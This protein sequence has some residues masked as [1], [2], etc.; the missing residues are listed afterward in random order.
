MRRLGTLI[1]GIVLGCVLGA[2]SGARTGCRVP[3]TSRIA[4]EAAEGDSRVRAFVEK[5]FRD[6]DLMQARAYLAEEGPNQ[7]RWQVEIS[8]RVCGCEGVAYMNVVRA[9]VDPCTGEVVSVELIPG[10]SES[11]YARR[12][13]DASC[14]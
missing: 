12:S 7:Y 2:W 13:C 6:E 11:D 10:I 9:C 3:T 8:E 5:R 4:I 14:H 1:V